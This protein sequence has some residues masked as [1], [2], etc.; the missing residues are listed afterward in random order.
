MDNRVDYEAVVGLCF[1]D[2]ERHFW[3]TLP[4]EQKQAFFYKLWTRKESFVKSVG[5][6]LAL[7]VSRVNT[8]LAGPSRFLSLPVG[9]GLPESWRLIDLELAEGLSGAVTVPVACSPKI[10]YRCLEDEARLHPCSRIS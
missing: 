6:G 3:L 7:D 9:Y 4:A 10:H 2:A 8:E 1:N 5:E